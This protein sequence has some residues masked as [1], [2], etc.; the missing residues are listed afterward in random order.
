MSLYDGY[1]YWIVL[2]IIV[3]AAISLIIYLGVRSSREQRSRSHHPSLR[4]IYEG[5]GE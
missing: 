2:A 3:I 4:H 1:L 5:D